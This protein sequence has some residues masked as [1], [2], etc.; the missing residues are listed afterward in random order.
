MIKIIIRMNFKTS[1]S[2]IAKTMND[3]QRNL[4]DK[5]E[6]RAKLKKNICNDEKNLIEKK[7][8][9]KRYNIYL[10]IHDFFMNLLTQNHDK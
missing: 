6:R 1:R 8:E 2:A 5:R 7:V 9:K 4:K 3:I 10:I